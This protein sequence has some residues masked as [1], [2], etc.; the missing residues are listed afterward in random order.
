MS[1]S[2][3]PS[4]CMGNILSQNHSLLSLLICVKLQSW[5]PLFPYQ[6]LQNLFSYFRYY[7]S[8]SLFDV[9]LLPSCQAKGMNYLHT[10]HP[11]VV[12]RDLKTPNLLVDRHWVVKVIFILDFFVCGVYLSSTENKS[13]TKSIEC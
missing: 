1:V 9:N 4:N 13:N 6:E 2:S 3:Q 11:P 5:G 7:F 10:S 12:H 8:L